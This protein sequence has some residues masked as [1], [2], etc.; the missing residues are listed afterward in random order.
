MSTSAITLKESLSA[1]YFGQLK[2]ES[3]TIRATFKQLKSD[4]NTLPPAT[5][6][7]KY[8]STSGI[9]KK[10]GAALC[11]YPIEL[12]T[13]RKTK[14]FFCK[15]LNGFSIYDVIKNANLKIVFQQNRTII[16]QDYSSDVYYNLCRI[17]TAM[18][19]T[20]YKVSSLYPEHILYQCMCN[21]FYLFHPFAYTQW[22]VKLEDIYQTY[23][24]LIETDIEDFY[25]L[26]RAN[27]F[28]IADSELVES[29]PRLKYAGK[30]KPESREEIL[31][32][33]QGEDMSQMKQKDII[34]R[35][36]KFYPKIGNSTIRN[37][38][39]KFGLT[40]KKYERKDYKEVHEHL[41]ELHEDILDATDE[42]NNKLDDGL[43]SIQDAVDGIDEMH[44]DMN[45]QFD[46][47]NYDM[48]ENFNAVQNH[49]RQMDAKLDDMIQRQNQT[50]VDTSNFNF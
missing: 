8:F 27:G 15:S 10:V 42:I 17:T 37:Q 26:A 21:M 46:K 30:L 4:F 9:I 29:E 3:Q 36:K 33:F 14:N 2:F 23:Y 31:E 50:V 11:E 13:G 43:D 48:H 39:A 44:E 7:Y 25:D 19:L 47:T 12:R 18:L 6:Y 34:A 40:L 49:L 35:I 24:K 38:M 41:D 16:I 45:S 5:L 1:N 28:Y 32:L 20:K 22:L